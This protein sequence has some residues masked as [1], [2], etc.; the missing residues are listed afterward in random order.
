MFDIYVQ[1]DGSISIS[2][3][4]DASQAAKA[5]AVLDTIEDSCIIDFKDLKYISSAGL[6]ELLSTQKRLMD[7]GK[8]L[9]LI[10]VRDN[11][12]DVFRFA[13]FHTIIEIE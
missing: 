5:K 4:F 2:G 10:N 12:K 6:G 13:G 7:K 1:P 3:R 8:G 9:K 11:I